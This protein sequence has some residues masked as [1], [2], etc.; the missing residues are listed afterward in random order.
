MHF[1]LCSDNLS[2]IKRTQLSFVAYKSRKSIFYFKFVN[3]PSEPYSS[4]GYN[5]ERSLPLAPD[6]RPHFDVLFPVRFALHRDSHSKEIMPL[7]ILYVD[8]Q[9]ISVCHPRQSAA[10][11]KAIFFPLL[12]TGEI[13]SYSIGLDLQKTLTVC[14]LL[15]GVLFVCTPYKR[16]QSQAMHT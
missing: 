3:C 15:A 9:Q 4:L 7:F 12:Y 14:E 11:P 5:K 16:I 2:S 6:Y 13:H 10:K 8:L 1:H